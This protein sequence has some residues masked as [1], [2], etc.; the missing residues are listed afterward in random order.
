MKV[1]NYTEDM[2]KSLPQFEH[3]LPGTFGRLPSAFKGREEAY[4]NPTETIT[5]VV[6]VP[7]D[8]GMFAEHAPQVPYKRSL[9][10]QIKRGKSNNRR[11][12]QHLEK[13]NAALKR[14]VRLLRAQLQTRAAPT[15]D[16]LA[17]AVTRG[18]EYMREEFFRPE[19][20]SLEEAS[21]LTGR[22]ERTINTER[23]RGWLYALLLE[24]NSRGYRY[25]K[26]QFDVPA[27]RLRPIL[28]ILRSKNFVGWALHNFFVTP[29]FDLDDQS[30]SAA[31]ANE[32][33]P[34]E[35]IANVARIRVDAHQGAA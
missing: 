12:V 8:T 19:N 31:I 16:P 25:P 34:L 13:E 7:S 2:N 17:A 10:V 3:L 30:P 23:N 11:T 35:R 15:A 9:A 4:A 22:S 18:A 14:E 27:A 24:G 21:V 26:W 32:E 33:F 1:M 28:D 6:A 29:H 5:H 20:L